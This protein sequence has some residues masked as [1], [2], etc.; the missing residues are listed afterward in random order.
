M[1]TASGSPRLGR[2]V[3]G[4][5]RRGWPQDG[6]G[7]GEGLGVRSITSTIRITLTIL[8]DSEICHPDKKPIPLPNKTQLTDWEEKKTP[9][10]FL[11]PVR[12]AE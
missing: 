2:G 5:V 8:T 6:R 7:Q 12:F 4:E 11:K 3:G 1:E 9:N 10:R